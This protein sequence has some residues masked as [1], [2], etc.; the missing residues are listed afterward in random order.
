MSDIK[1][2]NAHIPISEFSLDEM[3]AHPS[4]VMIAKRGSGKSWLARAILQKYKDIP[5]GVIIS[6]TE[7]DN[8]FYSKF[9]P[10]SFIYHEYN[11]QIIK[12]I[13]LRQKKIIKKAN[14]REQSGKPPIDP[15][16]I[17]IMDDCLASKG[18]W[19]RDPLIHDLLFNGR[20]R[21]IMY[22]LTMQ[23]PLGIIPEL[24][25]NFDYIFLLADD[26]ISNLRRIWE[27]YAG[28]FPDF[29]SFRQVFKQ[30]T[31]NYGSMVLKNRGVGGSL[32]DKIAFYKAPNLE[33]LTLNFGCNQFKTYHDK[34][35]D[36]EWDEKKF[37]IDYDELF[38]NKKKMNE[39]IAVKKVFKK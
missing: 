30:L 15:R 11:S 38:I 35:Y 9:F 25:S 10:Q 4:I 8:P 3:S 19:A 29:Y 17:I 24:R 2:D 14:E 34:N 27:H 6:P 16:I 13:L 23:F 20:H 12:K 39:R 37:A 33:S 18:S 22:I 31:D 7:I 1:L 36:S 21:Q 5:V 26:Q 32:F 28:V